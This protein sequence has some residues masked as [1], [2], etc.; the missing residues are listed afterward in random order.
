MKHIIKSPQ[1]PDL[2]TWIDAENDTN[3]RKLHYDYIDGALKRCIADALRAE[4]GYICCY[5]EREISDSDS[6]V[7]HIKPQSKF[8]LE[9]CNYAN[10]LCSCGREGTKGMPLHCGKSKDDW[11]DGSLFVS[12]LDAGCESRFM[13]T[14]DG[15]ILPANSSDEAAKET[16]KKCKL[17]LDNLKVRRKALIYSFI[18]D[19]LT[20]E[21]ISVMV[22]DHLSEK[23]NNSGKFKPFYTTIKYLFGR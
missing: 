6:H 3:V 12:P 4:Q 11:F 18:D 9:S 15:Q 16:I 2:E 17:N 10:M 8:P 14:V 20:A 23:H 21:E 5:C 22:A 7:E 1:P 13:F 19:E